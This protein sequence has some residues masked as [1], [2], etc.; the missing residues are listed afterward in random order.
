MFSD[1]ELEAFDLY[2]GISD[3]HLRWLPEH[4]LEAA[5]RGAVEG[6]FSMEDVER[7]LEVALRVARACSEADTYESH[8]RAREW[9]LRAGHASGGCGEWFYRLS[10][11]ELYTGRTA[12]ALEHALRGTAEEPGYPWNWLTAARL[13]LHFG[14]P[15]GARRCAESGLALVPG[16]GEFLAVLRGTGCGG[17]IEEMEFRPEGDDD[18]EQDVADAYWYGGGWVSRRAEAV[19]GI[20]T[21]EANLAAVKAALHPRGW[22]SDHPY[23]TYLADVDGRE[24]LVTLEMNAAFLSKLPADAVA[25]KIGM[26]PSMEAAC[27]PYLD[28]RGDS[29]GLC[30]VHVDRRLRA[31]LE[32][33][34]AGG[35]SNSVIPFDLEGRMARSNPLGGPFVSAVLL[36]EPEFDFGRLAR[37]LGTD[38]E[39]PAFGWLS[40]GVG[41]HSASV[42]LLPEPFPDGDGGHSAHLLVALI[43]RGGT[44][45]E[46]AG[47]HSELVRA[48]LSACDASGVVTGSVNVAPEGYED[49]ASRRPVANFVKASVHKMA[50]GGARGATDGMWMYGREEIEIS[51]DSPEGMADLML[52]AAAGILEA[53][54]FPE[55]GD[56]VRLPGGRILGI[57]R[58]RGWAVDGKSLKI[59][60][61]RQRAHRG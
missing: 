3:S 47:V 52:A 51:G 57:E 40:F 49:A 13:L 2:A 58:S 9:L 46:A 21:L 50:D 31:R 10:Y 25:R 34:D 54:M 23:C 12:L 32:F 41:P 60:Q 39:L 16:D 30:A 4:M 38:A 48:A 1:E 19:M 44:A 11:A 56:E 7:D 59:R 22:I 28:A 45:Y 6:R 29:R 24:V 33:G 53:D 15:E 20:S 27:R 42:E 26:V 17:G 43:N 18:P 55:S 8:L 5:S 37:V 35:G 36:D 14:D 61:V